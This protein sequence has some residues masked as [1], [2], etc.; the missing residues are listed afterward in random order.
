MARLKKL[1]AAQVKHFE[2][3]GYVF[4]IAVLS[5]E[6]VAS[7]QRC[8][9]E[10]L[11]RVGLPL[12]PSMRHKPHLFLKWASDLV[13]HPS[14]LDAVEDILGSHLL[15]WRSTFFIKQAHD[16][17]YF[18]W[19]Q[20]SAYWGFNSDAIVTAWIALTPSTRDNGCVRVLPGTHLQ[21]ELP[22]TIHF[23]G[24][25][26]L[27]R[28]QA[29]TVEV[30]D[31]RATN[32][33]LE[34]GDISLHHVRLLHGSL[35]NRSDGLRVGLAVRYIAPHVRPR[36][37]RQSG[38]LVRG[39]DNH[40]YF[41]HEPLPR[42]DDDPVAVEWHARSARRYGAQLI[43]ESLMKPTPRNLLTI[44]RIVANPRKLRSAVGYLLGWPK[45]RI[46]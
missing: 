39:V 6:E 17:H 28:G 2:T 21:P 27:V 4:P 32:I 10:F 44:A 20:D 31:D 46:H 29:V 7:Y 11:G 35:G 3:S 24:N 14:I 41:D 42:Y 37:P 1:T 38:T 15:V 23:D 36:G 43:R 26:S 30:P 25:N 33:E 22:H 5:S 9:E 34:A 16:P 45:S 19:H 12:D 40:G 18:P 13:R 8:L